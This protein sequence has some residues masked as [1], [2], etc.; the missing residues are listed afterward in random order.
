[1]SKEVVQ[2]K[3]AAGSNVKKVAGS[4]SFHL[5][6]NTETPPKQVEILACGASAVNQTVKA[7]AISSGHIAQWGGTLKCRMG[8]DNITI[9]DENRTAMRFVC[10]VE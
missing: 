10:D 1:M 3:V 4:L 7:I 9:N 5:K 6:G 8:F 2:F